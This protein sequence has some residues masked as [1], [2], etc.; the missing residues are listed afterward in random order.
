MMAALYI[1]IAIMMVILE[2]TIIYIGF[3]EMAKLGL[4]ENE[5]MHALINAFFALV[6]WNIAA[7]ALFFM[8]A[9][10]N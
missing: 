2:T 1:I 4:V 3:S 5:Q 10:L 7:G 8:G 9:F 6:A